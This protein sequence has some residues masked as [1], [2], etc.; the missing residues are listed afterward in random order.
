MTDFEGS[1]PPAPLGFAQFPKEI[2]LPPRA[3][4]ERNAG[5]QLLHYTAFDRGGHFAALES[6]DLLVDDV[7]LFFARVRERQ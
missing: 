5:D 6:P 3:W 4:V 2:N 1:G 7:R